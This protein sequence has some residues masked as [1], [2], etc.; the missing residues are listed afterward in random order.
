LKDYDG[1]V[2]DLDGTLWD[3]AVAT[4]MGWNAALAACGLPEHRVS[5]EDVRGV[6]G[7]PFRSCVE[8]ILP[9]SVIESH[10]DVFVALNAYERSWVE[11]QGGRPYDGVVV[12][13]ERLSQ[14]YPLFLVSNCQ[15]WYLE[16]FWSL[17]GLQACFEDWDC[18]GASAL[19][20]PAM[21]ADIIERHRLEAAIFVGDTQDD[22]QA[23]AAAGTDFGYAAYGFGHL[24]GSPLEFASFE[25]LV[26]W[27]TSV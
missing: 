6:S 2:F 15:K 3:A 22:A 18:H 12:G 10:P 1:I 20:K 23:A 24:G 16:V 11:A 7:K 19:G 25:A 4:A 21:L 27:F 14:H 8:A 26:E 9:G 5:A 17:F 13:I